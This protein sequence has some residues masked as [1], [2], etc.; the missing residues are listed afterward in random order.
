MI[1]AHVQSGSFKVCEQEKIDTSNLFDPGKG[2]FE[3]DTES[4]VVYPHNLMSRDT[5]NPHSGS[6]CLKVE[7]VDITNGAYLYLSTLGDL[8]ADLVVGNW[9]V[10]KCW[11]KVNTGAVTIK[12]NSNG[13]IDAGK[14]IAETAWT[15][16]ELIFRAGTTNGCYIQIRSIDSGEIIWV[17][18]ITLQEIQPLTTGDSFVE[19]VTDGSYSFPQPHAY[20]TWE[21][22]VYNEDTNV[23]TFI[24]QNVLG[25][26][27]ANDSY[28]VM[29]E[30]G[31]YVK[32]IRKT[33]NILSVAS[34]VDRYRWHTIKI[35]RTLD[36][37]FMLYVDGALI[38]TILSALYTTSH[39]AVVEGDTGDRIRNFKW[40]YGAINTPTLSIPLEVTA[41]QV[42]FSVSGGGM[43]DQTVSWDYP[44]GTA[45]NWDLNPDETLTS[46]G[47]VWL[48]FWKMP[49]WTTLV[50]DI[51][52]T[53]NRF[54]GNLSVFAPFAYWIY[55]VTGLSVEGN[56][57][58][59]SSIAHTFMISGAS[60][61]E[62]DV[63]SLSGVQHTL[64]IVRSPLI[65]GD[66]GS[67]SGV[68]NT[69]SFYGCPLIT[70]DLSSVSGLTY[71]LNLDLCSLVTGDLSSISGLTY[72]V[73]LDHCLLVTGDL[74]SL[75]SVTHDV[76][77]TDCV[78]I[79][80]DLSSLDAGLTVLYLANC[81]LVTGNLSSVNSGADS[82]DLDNCHLIE[83]NLSSLNAVVYT[84]SLS[85]CPLIEGSLN[86]VN[87]V[88]TQL[89][90]NDCVKIT[91]ILNPTSVVLYEIY[92]NN[93]D[94]SAADISQSLINVQATV[95][96]P[97]T[98]TAT[99]VSIGNL[100]P[101]GEAARAALVAAGWTVTLGA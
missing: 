14:S 88:M 52:A 29:V 95:I 65:T 90:L 94:T 6:G 13:G 9:Y 25:Y 63:S 61:V 78:L 10:V 75:S 84:I 18:D 15:F 64:S 92:L 28:S 33:S 100:T 56:L 53:Y 3:V 26:D 87:G 36:G 32:L 5:T 77:L 20:G 82:V 39:F 62:G 99:H 48:N 22:E 17:D 68:T 89:H 83:G 2:T 37:T 74:S 85:G 4:W 98:F 101:A 8:G 42:N 31:G 96:I 11:A 91:G 51:G 23:I 73:N 86:S 93:T 71:K 19:C 81:S 67:V 27:G 59:V 70:G 45:T 30:K 55:L 21:F 35:T 47:T 72:Y 49:D 12:A 43:T 60:L 38:G 97:G 41:G 57:S 34:I 79:T 69:L 58:S 46:G 44:D 80:G 16:V 7:Y 66:L 76:R 50:F 24:G 54:V 40:S 1:S